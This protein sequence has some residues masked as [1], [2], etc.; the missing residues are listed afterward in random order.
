M[1]KETV[2]VTLKMPEPVY[3]FY[4]ALAETYKQSLEE[5]IL[6]ELIQDVEGILDTEEPAKILV[7]TFGLQ[8]YI[9]RK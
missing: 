9:K 6:E 2:E 4:M 3:R 1:N 5:V 7:G 8:D